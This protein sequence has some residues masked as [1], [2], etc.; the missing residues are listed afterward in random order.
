MEAANPINYYQECQKI[1]SS[2]KYRNIYFWNHHTIEIQEHELTVVPS[3][4]SSSEKIKGIVIEAILTP[5]VDIERKLDLSKKVERIF[6]DLSAKSLEFEINYDSISIKF[7]MQLCEN[8][9]VLKKIIPE[10][11]ILDT[12][13]PV[14][15]GIAPGEILGEISWYKNFFNSTDDQKIKTLNLLSYEEKV[16]KAVI[17][18]YFF[19]SAA[20]DEFL[21]LLFDIDQRNPG[22]A[23]RF[24]QEKREFFS[25][26]LLDF[27]FVYFLF[28]YIQAGSIFLKASLL[29]MASLTGLT[30]ELEKRQIELC[31]LVDF[32]TLKKHEEI[33]Q[34]SFSRKTVYTSLALADCLTKKMCDDWMR[35]LKVR[36]PTFEDLALILEY[37]LFFSSKSAKE[38]FIMSLG[39]FLMSKIDEEPLSVL[40][41]KLEC[42]PHFTKAMEELSLSDLTISFIVQMHLTN[43]TIAFIDL[44]DSLENIRNIP[45]LV[46]EYSRPMQLRISNLVFND[47][48]MKLLERQFPNV[49]YLDISGAK[50]KKIPEIWAKTIETLNADDAEIEDEIPVFQKANQ[51]YLD[52]RVQGTRNGY[53]SLQ[54]AYSRRVGFDQYSPQDQL[55]LIGYFIEQALL[56]SK[57]YWRVHNIVLEDG[58]ISEVKEE[59]VHLSQEVA[60]FF[61][62]TVLSNQELSIKEG[63]ALLSAIERFGLKM[64]DNSI[65]ISVTIEGVLRKIPISFLHRFT[66]FYQAAKGFSIILPEHTTLVD[67]DEFIFLLS[68]RTQKN[69]RILRLKDISEHR[70]MNVMNIVHTF[71]DEAIEREMNNLRRLHINV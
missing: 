24:L 34:D 31:D 25:P 43:Q 11:G 15:P 35:R 2:P 57:D 65:R 70:F 26:K 55:K 53:I 17:I 38:L 59:N 21:D 60:D 16:F 13:M 36:R 3:S 12:Q 62:Y 37:P 48:Q 20:L 4:N 54:K 10:I 9:S 41:S 18:E 50:I 32:I 66:K 22:E 56:K 63:K 8:S 58:I 40:A 68:D 30:F 67:F 6:P 23:F 71:C 46:K 27:F 52:L 19:D 42:L 14:L 45:W 49:K 28:H 61:V 1:F 5:Y 33:D 64:Q 39:S 29:P 47:H 7:P 44:E 69:P 51:L